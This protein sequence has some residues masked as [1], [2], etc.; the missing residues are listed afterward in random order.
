MAQAVDLG[1]GM[2][3]EMSAERFQWLATFKCSSLHLTHNDHASNYVTAKVWIEEY[4]PAW[5]GDETPEHI[6]A[7]KDADT[8]WTLQIYPTTPVGFFKWNRA[9]LEEA[10]DAA[11]EHFNGDDAASSS[12][13]ERNT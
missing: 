11:M 1:A 2:V 7:M 13:T 9:T 5:F 10:V 12:P 4:E 8:I 3:G 6:Q